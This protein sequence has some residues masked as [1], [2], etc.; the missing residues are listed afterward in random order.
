MPT[1]QYQIGRKLGEAA[2]FRLH[3]C[4]IGEGEL[5]I[6]KVAIDPLGDGLLDREALILQTLQVKAERLEAQYT[7]IKTQPQDFLNYQLMFP[8]LV[9][10]FHSPELADRRVNV[11]K[12]AVPTK[13]LEVWEPLER[14]WS[15]S[16]V[17]LDPRSSAWVLGKLLKVLAF[18][19]EQGMAVNQIDGSN[20]LI[21]PDQH[22]VLIFD[23]T[24][25]RS[26][27][28]EVPA[29]IA[30]AEI[31]QAASLL[32]SALGGDLATGSLPADDQLVDRRYADYLFKLTRGEETDTA[33]TQRE[34]YHLV[35]SL[36]PR[37]FH[38]FT[39]YPLD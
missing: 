2:S 34:F 10:S 30:G 8:L 9:E 19:H 1:D 11:I 12:F 29:E 7:Q 32:V 15:Q 37:Q 24:Q 39:T 36:W 28:H 31:A 26:Y 20:I 3:E 23:W 13:D 18:A 21:N 16:R 6:L 27:H 4:P 14:L 17:R 25:A 22:Y 38:P 35:R 33:K 5:G